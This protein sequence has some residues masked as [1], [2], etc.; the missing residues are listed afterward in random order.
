MC[1]SCAR[2]Q[3]PKRDYKLRAAICCIHFLGRS[4]ATLMAGL[5]KWE[6][7]SRAQ[8][9]PISSDQSPLARHGELPTKQ[10]MEGV[11]RRMAAGNG[12]G[13]Q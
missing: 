12:P 2:M 6:T 8:I 13:C 7:D 11:L 3:A 5:W 1:A 4:D 9:V 10:R